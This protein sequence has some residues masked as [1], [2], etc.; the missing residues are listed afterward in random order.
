MKK[1]TS[2][3]EALENHMHKQLLLHAAG[4]FITCPQCGNILD[5]STVII[6]DVFKA[7]KTVH[8]EKK[9]FCTGCVK[10]PST[11]KFDDLERENNI[12]I[13]IMSKDFTR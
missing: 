3:T 13:E 7:K 1:A 5:W 12:Q 6:L 11:I 10:D 8:V 9:I 2:V 4:T